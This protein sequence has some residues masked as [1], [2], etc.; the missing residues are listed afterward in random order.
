MLGFLLW[1]L[2]PLST[3]L[4]SLF[5]LQ[6]SKTFSLLIIFSKNS[7]LFKRKKNR[8]VQEKMSR[9]SYLPIY[10]WWHPHTQCPLRCNRCAVQA[11]F[12]V[13]LW[14]PSPPPYSVISLLQSLY[15]QFPLY[16]VLFP[17]GYERS[18][19]FHNPPKYLTSCDPPHFRRIV[20]YKEWA[21]LSCHQRSWVVY[22]CTPLFLIY[23]MKRWYQLISKVPSLVNTGLWHNP[24]IMYTLGKA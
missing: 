13:L 9:F 21:L 5:S 12:K 18:L 15:Y 6:T 1:F 17:S 10:P 3:Q 20:I 22:L 7:L 11:V 19:Q 23:K 4:S 16:A 24:L 2:F 8:K 14:I